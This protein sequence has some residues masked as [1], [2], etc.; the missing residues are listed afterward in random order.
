[1]GVHKYGPDTSSSQLD[2]ES[3][4]TLIPRTVGHRLDHF[5]GC[6]ICFVF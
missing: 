6:I 2:I 5:T 1:M 4:G 3:L